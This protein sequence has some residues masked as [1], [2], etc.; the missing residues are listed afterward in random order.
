MSDELLQPVTYDL[1]ELI[2]WEIKILFEKFYW[3]IKIL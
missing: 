3:E 2:D 1:C